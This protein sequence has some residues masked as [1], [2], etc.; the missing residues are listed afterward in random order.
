MDPMAD[1][2]KKPGDKRIGTGYELRGGVQGSARIRDKAVIIR[3]EPTDRKK[4]KG[5]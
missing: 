4:P 3:R 2:K 1:D 5:S